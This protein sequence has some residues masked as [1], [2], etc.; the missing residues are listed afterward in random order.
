MLDNNIKVDEMSKCYF[1]QN[2]NPYPKYH[3][4]SAIRV[5]SKLIIFTNIQ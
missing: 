4:R 5:Y 1:R 3:A 2:V